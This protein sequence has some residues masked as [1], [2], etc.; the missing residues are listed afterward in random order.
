M[1]K[2]LI[3]PFTLVYFVWIEGSLATGNR[4]VSG[5]I[6][7]YNTFETCQEAG[8]LLE[9]NTMVDQVYCVWVDE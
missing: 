6:R 3:L 5:E 8:N 4:V 7:S 9:E 1:T 2:L